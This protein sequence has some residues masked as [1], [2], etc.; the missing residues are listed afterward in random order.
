M[1]K[2]I[3]LPT[4]CFTFFSFLWAQ[5]NFDFRCV[6]DTIQSGSSEIT[7]YFI[8]ENTGTQPD[9][10]V[11]NCRVVDSVPGWFEMYCV[12]GL[13]SEPGIPLYD[14]LAPGLADSAIDIQI[15]PSLGY[16]VEKVNLHVQSLNNSS[17]KDSINVYAIGTNANEEDQATADLKNQNRGWTVSPNPFFRFVKIGF[18]KK[19]AVPVSEI[20]VYDA[21]GRRI[22]NL[23]TSGRQ[24]QQIQLV[25]NGTDNDGRQI[26]AGIYFIQQKNDSEKSTARL[27]KIK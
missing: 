1:K 18:M 12:H 13:C 10:Y 26:P 16:G 15:F 7:F 2:T 27:I 22:K 19:D 24:G 21:R 8:L 9:S 6:D 17:L 11:F 3:I 14:H 23:I 4:I 25:W 20:V 5:Y